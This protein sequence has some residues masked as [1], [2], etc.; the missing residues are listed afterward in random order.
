MTGLGKP[1]GVRSLCGA[2]FAVL[3]SG[4]A[5][6]AAAF[7]CEPAVFD[8][9]GFFADHDRNRDGM[10][11][12]TELLAASDGSTGYGPAL[13]RPINTTAAFAQLDRNND[14]GVD[15]SELEEWRLYTDDPCAA[16]NARASDQQVWWRV[17]WDWL[18]GL[19][20]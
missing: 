12:R 1:P 20:R 3:V 14:A 2:R 4:F 19:W 17:A 9:D 7:A 6:S 18:T 8:F 10:L 11:Q 13:E 16:W 5:I 15:R